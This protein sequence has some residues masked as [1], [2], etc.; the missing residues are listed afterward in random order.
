VSDNISPTIIS[1]IFNKT[2]IKP[3]TKRKFTQITPTSPTDIKREENKERCKIRRLEIK[4]QKQEL[5]NLNN[6]KKIEIFFNNKWVEVN[7]LKLS[8]LKSELKARKA[9]TQ[10]NKAELIRF[11]NDANLNGFEE[12]IRIFNDN[13]SVDKYNFE[14]LTNIKSP[15][16]ELKALN[17]SKKGLNSSSQHF[18]GLANYIYIGNE[19]LITRTNNIWNKKGL[20]N[21]TNGII[22][23]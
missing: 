6:E 19:C 8:E 4:N 13:D 5:E 10:G 20:C 1:H 15:I 23:V 22:K 18:G 17:S 7:T 9:N 3:T 14:K 12:A 2:N 21:G 16:A 11:V